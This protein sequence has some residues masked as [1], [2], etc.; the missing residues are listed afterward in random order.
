LT[1]SWNTIDIELYGGMV[2]LMVLTAVFQLP[3]CGRLLR[4]TRQFAAFIDTAICSI[5]PLPDWCWFGH[6]EQ[7]ECSALRH[8]HVQYL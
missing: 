7:T 6:Y 2:K 1:I 8:Y 3:C 5:M 4:G